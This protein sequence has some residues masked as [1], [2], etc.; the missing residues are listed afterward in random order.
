MTE[1]SSSVALA[2]KLIRKKGRSGVSMYRAVPGTPV[3]S[4][5]WK[6]EAPSVD[7]LLALNMNVL[8]LDE[9]QARGE[10]GQFGFDVSFRSSV[11]MPDALTSSAT[12]VAYIIPAQMGQ[13]IPKA[14][15]LIVSGTTRYTVLRCD[16]L[17]PGNELVLYHV[18][19]M[20]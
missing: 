17:R 2:A 8:F 16:A 10:Q 1:Y 4:K 18:Q 15:D 6:F 7:Q 19:L 5:P 9:R 13:F 12:A 20:E 14:G 3:T 11:N